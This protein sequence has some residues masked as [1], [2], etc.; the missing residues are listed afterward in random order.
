VELHERCGRAAAASGVA[1]L[2]TVGG[3]PAR[4]LGRAAVAAGFPPAGVSHA[5]SSVEAAEIAVH[6]VGPGDLVLVKGSRGIATERVVERL[7]AEFG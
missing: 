2:V 1:W 4:A 5:G 6:R 3:E 7:R